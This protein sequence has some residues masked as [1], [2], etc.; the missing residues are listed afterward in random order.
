M[1]LKLILDIKNYENSPQYLVW[2]G[3]KKEA[4]Y[5]NSK[6]MTWH[7]VFIR[8]CFAVYLKSQSK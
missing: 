4:S 3:Q 5:K 7:P 1:V 6:S 8:W 2:E